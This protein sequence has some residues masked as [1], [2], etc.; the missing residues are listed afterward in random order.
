MF[1]LDCLNVLFF[2]RRR[3]RHHW[4][5]ISLDGFVRGVNKCIRQCETMHEKCSTDFY[6]IYKT[7]SLTFALLQFV[8]VLENGGFGFFWFCFCFFV[9]ISK[10]CFFIENWLINWS[11]SLIISSSSFIRH[12][13]NGFQCFVM[14][15][16]YLKH[17]VFVMWN[18]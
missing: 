7:F 12:K 11:H 17:V 16:R 18:V 2:V 13:R 1:C 14:F 5:A 3:R 4:M 9:Y 8:W 15:A 10:N 6:S